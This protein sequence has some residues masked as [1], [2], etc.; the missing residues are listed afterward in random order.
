MD[1][2]LM[3]ILQASASV[4]A[5]VIV[6][7]ALGVLWWRSHSQWLLLAIA[8]EGVSLLFRLAFVAAPSAMAGTSMLLLVWPVTGL[9]MAAGLLGY[10]LDAPNR[11]P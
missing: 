4:L 6:L 10:A 9:L 7:A 5:A 2:H 1:Q 8:A 11:R 3:Q